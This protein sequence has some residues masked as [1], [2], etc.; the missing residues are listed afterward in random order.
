MKRSSLLLAVRGLH[1]ALVQIASLGLGG[2][3]WFT[4]MTMAWRTPPPTAGVADANGVLSA[5]APYL[6]A[7]AVHSATLCYVGGARCAT[8]AKSVIAV[9]AGSLLTYLLMSLSQAQYA[10]LEAQLTDPLYSALATTILYYAPGWALVQWL[11]PKPARD[12]MTEAIKTPITVAS[13]L[14]AAASA[15][16]YAV[17]GSFAISAVALTVVLLAAFL[18]VHWVYLG[19]IGLGAGAPRH[20]FRG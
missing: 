2:F 5:A 7:V 10:L 20:R 18:L 17:S 12:S 6:A 4:L 8:Q 16:A 11:R 3:F 1:F 13:C 14:G 15:A 19:R 9:L